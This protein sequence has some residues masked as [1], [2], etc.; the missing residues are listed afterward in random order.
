MV[1]VVSLVRCNTQ[2]G[3]QGV[4]SGSQHDRG[5]GIGRNIGRRHRGCT[6][7]PTVLTGMGH[8]GRC[9][10]IFQQIQVGL[11]RFDLRRL[12]NRR[13]TN[14]SAQEGKKSLPE[15]RMG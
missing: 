9:E 2:A 14:G 5:T 4:R 3:V 11:E 10:P 8:G 1:T 7:D 6:T 12:A 15:R 13:A